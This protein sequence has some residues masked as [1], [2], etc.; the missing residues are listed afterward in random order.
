MLW[1]DLE[2][3]EDPHHNHGMDEHLEFYREAIALRKNHD[4]FHNGNFKTVLLDDSRNLWGFIRSNAREEIL[5]VLNAGSTPAD[6]E[7]TDLGEGWTCIFGAGNDVPP[8][9]RIEAVEGR[10]WAR[11]A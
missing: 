3:Y 7:F 5:V 2:P 10:A 9:I 8:S 11:T 1:K 6:V 4:A